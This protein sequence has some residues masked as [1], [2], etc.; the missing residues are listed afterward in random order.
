MPEIESEPIT[1]NSFKSLPRLAFITWLFVFTVDAIFIAPSEHIKDFAKIIS[2]WSIGFGFATAL[3]SLRIYKKRVGTEGKEKG[4]FLFIPLNALLIFFYASAYNGFTIQVGSW[5]EVNHIF[6]EKEKL[7]SL[8]KGSLLGAMQSF[9]SPILARQTSYWPDVKTLAEKN[10]LHEELHDVE[11]LNANLIDSLTF[12]R[13]V[14]SENEELIKKISYYE[15]RIVALEQQVDA[16]QLGGNQLVNGLR[17]EVSIL[18]DRSKELEL[19]VK[20]LIDRI[21]RNNALQNEWKGKT[22][23]S[24]SRELMNSRNCVNCIRSLMGREFYYEFFEKPI[25]TSR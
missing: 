2:V 9:A 15:E 12:F 19:Y 24:H 10:Q 21:E 23:R 14:T 4:D 18:K 1:W 17:N 22:Q 25:E 3:E 7:D 11:L 6:L 16:N 8:D 5:S 13:N 20:I